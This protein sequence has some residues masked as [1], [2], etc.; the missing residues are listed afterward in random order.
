MVRHVDSPQISRALP[1]GLRQISLLQNFVLSSLSCFISSQAKFAPNCGG[2]SRPPR[3]GA[4]VAPQR[5]LDSLKT[6]KNISDI[7]GSAKTTTEPNQSLGFSR[8]R[9]AA[10]KPRF[11]FRRKSQTNIFPWPITAKP[12]FSPTSPAPKARKLRRNWEGRVRGADLRSP[13]A[14]DSSPRGSRDRALPRKCRSRE[15]R[16]L[17]TAATWRPAIRHGYGQGAP[18]A[19]ASSLSWRT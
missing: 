18:P 11:R 13:V 4:L 8:F 19:A 5:S 15:D 10:A 2:T 3:F 17:E 1:H 6:A 16:G 12:R 7:F 9:S 14:A